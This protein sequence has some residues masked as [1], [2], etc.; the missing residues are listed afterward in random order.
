MFPH[1]KIT[2]PV[3]I[4]FCSL[5]IIDNQNPNAFLTGKQLIYQNIN[6]DI[7]KIFIGETITKLPVVWSFKDTLDINLIL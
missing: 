4:A 6:Y 7:Q 3:K 2:L 5:R 1:L